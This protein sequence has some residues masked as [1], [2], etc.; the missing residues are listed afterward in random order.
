MLLIFRFL[1]FC[2]FNFNPVIVRGDIFLHGP[3]LGL[4]NGQYNTPFLLSEI[5]TQFIYY[6]QYT[7][8]TT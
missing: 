1:P 5:I 8:C 6:R 4:R 7:F 3:L 2:N